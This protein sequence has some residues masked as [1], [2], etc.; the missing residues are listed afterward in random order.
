[1]ASSTAVEVFGLQS[2]LADL[3][4]NRAPR[5]LM[6]QMKAGWFGLVGPCCPCG[7]IPKGFEEL[8]HFLL[9][10]NVSVFCV[11]MR[12]LRVPESDL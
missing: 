9:Q 4:S 11:L 3:P 1:M 5:P 2:G 7:Q 6:D 10:E 12:P 8:L